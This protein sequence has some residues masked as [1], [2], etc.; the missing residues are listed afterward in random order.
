MAG[1]EWLL[2]PHLERMP[3]EQPVER[4]Q[5]RLSLAGASGKSSSVKILNSNTAAHVRAQSYA[6]QFQ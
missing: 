3:G 5:S 2:L 4:P 6:E 1:S